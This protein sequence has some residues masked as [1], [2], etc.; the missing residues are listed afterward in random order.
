MESEYMRLLLVVLLAVAVIFAVAGCSENE[1]MTKA[2]KVENPKEK[3]AETPKPEEAAAKKEAVKEETPKPEAKAEE[4]KPGKDGW[5]T[6]KSGLKYKDKKVG[7]GAAVKS[8]DAVIV[9][10]KGWLDDGTVFD[11]SKKPGRKPLP[12]TVDRGDVIEGWEEGVKG[13]KVGGTRE[14]N[15]PPDLG[16]GERGG[17]PIP[18]NSTLH[19]DVELLQ[20][21]K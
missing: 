4:P 17:G 10:Y 16:Y 5:V 21:N 19:F 20:I 14:L 12:F 1:E 6:T 7:K 18:P 2:T 8:G 3:K 15:I 9:H 11:T 13:M